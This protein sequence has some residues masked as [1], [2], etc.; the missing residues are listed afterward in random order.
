MCQLKCV[1]VTDNGE[2]LLMEEVTYLEV[3]PEAIKCRNLFGEEFEYRLQLSSI[4]FVEGK[5]QLK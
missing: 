5:I 1:K 4:D 3:L 2:D